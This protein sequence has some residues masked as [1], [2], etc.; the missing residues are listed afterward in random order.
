MIWFYVIGGLGIVVMMGLHLKARNE[1]NLWGIPYEAPYLG[2][3]NVR[4]WSLFI[5]VRY[6]TVDVQKMF[7][8]PVQRT[9][10]KYGIYKVSKR[11]VNIHKQEG[12]I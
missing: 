12:Q 9:R 10:K 2:Q 11:C 8:F 3:I 7:S 5:V 4:V 6:K 1:Y